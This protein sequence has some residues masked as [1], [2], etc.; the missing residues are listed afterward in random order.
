MYGDQAPSLRNVN[1]WRLQ[2]LRGG[3]L[4]LRNAEKCGRRATAT[5]QENIEAA[6]SYIELNP[7]AKISDVGKEIGVSHGTAFRILH[8][9]L[10][11]Q[12]FGGKWIPASLK[13]DGQLHTSGAGDG[14]VYA[15]ETDA[16]L[17]GEQYVYT[18]VTA[19][20]HGNTQLVAVQNRS[21]LLPGSSQR[22]R[23]AGRQSTSMKAPVSVVTVHPRARRGG[24]SAGTPRR[25]EY[26]KSEMDDV[27]AMVSDYF[28]LEEAQ[29][30][31]GEG[32]G[33]EQT[34][35]VVMGVAPDGS[36][37]VVS[38]DGEGAEQQDATGYVVQE[39]TGYVVEETNYI[40]YPETA[41]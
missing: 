40:N 10:K 23:T 16:G 39:T 8:E 20:R 13:V 2:F 5:T 36:L 12:N 41:M 18:P 34:G 17:Q 1:F 25:N 6:R 35:D 4:R 7:H 21:Q 15:Y 26:V 27:H 38:V 3:R 9:H 29:H 33:D 24:A 19:R 37:Y 14:L 32:E 30:Q 28:Q 22:M 11:L 31:E